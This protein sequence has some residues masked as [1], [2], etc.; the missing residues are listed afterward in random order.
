[1][2]TERKKQK[3]MENERKWGNRR[4]GNR[5]GKQGGIKKRAR[6]KEI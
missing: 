2:A 4:N 3:E 6:G 5:E 1:M